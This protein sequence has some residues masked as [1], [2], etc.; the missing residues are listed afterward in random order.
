MSRRLLVCLVAAAVLAAGCGSDAREASLGLVVDPA[1]AVV[2]IATRGCG[3]GLLTGLGVVLD[4]GRILTAAHVV[5][6]ATSVEVVHRSGASS[7]GE[8]MALDPGRDLAVLA[9]DAGDGPHTGLELGTLAE[10]QHAVVHG[11]GEILEV[12]V[13]RR[14]TMRAP[15]IRLEQEAER[16][17]LELTVS[18]SPG[19][20][21]APVLDR[22]GRV[23]GVVVAASD[24]HA[25]A[26]DE[27]EIRAVLDATG[28]GPI[29]PGDCA[30]IAVYE[31]SLLGEVRVAPM[32]DRPVG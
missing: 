3:D 7:L 17:V 24:D 4:D 16:R 13:T 15:D 30:V 25:Y 23:G 2:S 8:L 6:G 10:G 20:S 26:A 1:D 12:E 29:D 11:R 22:D 28:S 14:L 5:A 9:V 27:S 21:G 31:C 32:C 19:W 18:V